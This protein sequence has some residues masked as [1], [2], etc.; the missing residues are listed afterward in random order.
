MKLDALEARIRENKFGS[1]DSADDIR[2]NEERLRAMFE[3]TGDGILLVDRETYQVCYANQTFCNLLGY[4]REEISGISV[5]NVHSANTQY[6]LDHLFQRSEMGKV[7]LLENIPLKRKNGPVFYT[8]IQIT[9]LRIAGCGYIMADFRDVTERKQAEAELK[10]NEMRL[11]SLLELSEKAYQ[12]SEQEI[13][14]TVAGGTIRLT[15]SEIGCIYFIDQDGQC[16]QSTSSFEQETR[17]SQIS[18]EIF[19]LLEQ[20]GLWAECIETQKPVIKNECNRML[21]KKE[22]AEEHYHLLSRLILVPIIEKGTVSLILVVGNKAEDY[23]DTDIKQVQLIGYQLIRILERKQADVSLKRYAKEQSALYAVTSAASAFL[24][25]DH[26]LTTVLNLVLNLPG[27]AADTGWV[28]VLEDW[29]R[30]TPR[31]VAMKGCQDP[32]P[33]DQLGAWQRN[34]KICL[35]LLDNQEPSPDTVPIMPCACS[36]YKCP[37]NHDIQSH[38]AV[39]IRTGKRTLGLIILAWRKPIPFT[40][41]DYA[42][43][44]AIGKQVGLGLRN[45]QLYQAAAQSNRLK[46]LNAL[47]TAAG[48]SLEMDVVLKQVL[49]LTCSAVQAASGAILQLDPNRNCLV[50]SRTYGQNSENLQGMRLPLDKGIAGWVAEHSQVA[51]VNDVHK[52][53]RWFDVFDQQTNFETHSVLCAPLLYRGGGYRGY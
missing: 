14:R 53:N 7:E 1:A 28:T 13:T 45:A 43:L 3:H 48:S 17:Y 24:D 32:M 49:D 6:R 50:F 21:G 19:L 10:L 8:D 31:L 29:P 2:E 5:R 36:T 22:E 42:L 27:I 41:A 52:D 47:S 38:I 11:N 39:P 37:G 16:I 15:C 25:P 33:R 46:V 23:D 51:C 26:L 35:P 9:Y 40:S 18:D 34:C 44:M 4:S 30:N 20:E 12:L